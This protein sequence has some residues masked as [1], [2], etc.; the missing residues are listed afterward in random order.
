V[1][2]AIGILNQDWRHN[3]ELQQKIVE[4]LAQ[5]EKASAELVTLLDTLADEKKRFESVSTDTVGAVDLF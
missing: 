3:K 1:H 4:H 2:Q 5:S